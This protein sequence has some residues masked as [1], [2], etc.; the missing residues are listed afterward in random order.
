MADS[1]IRKAR[2]LNEV[3]QNLT[4]DS[5]GYKGWGEVNG[6]KKGERGKVVERRG[7]EGK[8]GVKRR[9][10]GDGGRRVIGGKSSCRGRDRK[11]N[12]R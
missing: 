10:E 6:E 4:S 8:E 2:L 7:G 9:G 12:E 5:S 11:R 3:I 1:I